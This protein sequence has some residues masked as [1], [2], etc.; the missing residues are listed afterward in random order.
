MSNIV[1]KPIAADLV[2]KVSRYRYQHVSSILKQEGEI[3]ITGMGRKTAYHARKRLEAILNCDVQMLPGT[4]K[5]E[6]GY[7]FKVNND[8]QGAGEERAGDS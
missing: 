4:W 6:D 5:R 7:Y 2:L 3:F 8:G 1:R